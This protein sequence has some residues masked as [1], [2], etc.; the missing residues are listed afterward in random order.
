[1]R[2]ILLEDSE[3]GKANQVVEV[4]DGYAK[5][6]LIKRG[7][8]VPYNLKTK[9]LLDKKITDLSQK[10]ET[11]NFELTQ[12]KN[13]IESLSFSFNLKVVNQRIHGSITRKQ[14]CK[15]LR[16]HQIEVNPLWI[17]N[18]KIS[19]LGKTKVPIKLSKNITAW[20]PIEV[21]SD[22]N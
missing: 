6:Y 1:M 12:L 5:N 7:V 19:V 2:I 22:G 9:H 15:E 14:I 17:E 13:A 18:L 20:L 21:K 11:R 4:K 16:L 10:T 3:L 8:A